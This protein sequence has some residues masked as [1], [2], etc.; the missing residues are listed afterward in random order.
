MTGLK[1]IVNAIVLFIRPL[2]RNQFCSIPSDKNPVKLDTT[3]DDR[4]ERNCE[5]NRPFYSAFKKE[6]ILFDS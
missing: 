1:E 6:P 3:H 2:K 4:V 5:S